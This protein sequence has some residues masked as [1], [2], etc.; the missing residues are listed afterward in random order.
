HAVAVGEVLEVHAV[1]GVVAELAAI[2]DRAHAP[3]LGTAA[4]GDEC[5]LRVAGALGDNV[6]HAI[7]GVGAP[8]G[9]AGAANDLYAFD[10]FQE[11]VALVPEHPAKG[12]RVQTPAVHHH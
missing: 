4:A 7:D 2:A 5:S 10:V 9:G 6:D 12:G 1:I 11:H 8:Q 3:G